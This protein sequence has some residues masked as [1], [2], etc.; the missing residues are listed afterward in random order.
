MITEMPTRVSEL[1]LGDRLR[2]IRRGRGLTVREF[3]D[4]IFTSP[5]SYSVYETTSVVS[6]QGAKRLAAVIEAVH[7]VPASWT[8]G[9]DASQLPR[10]DSNLQP[11]D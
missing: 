2:L 4:S 5:G 8:L 6:P 10:R 7:G 11:A 1:S 9:E 3:A